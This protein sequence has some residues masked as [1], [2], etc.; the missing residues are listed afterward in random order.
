MWGNIRV[1]GLR[2]GGRSSRFPNAPGERFRSKVLGSGGQGVDMHSL[3]S[4]R[5][6]TQAFCRMSLNYFRSCGSCQVFS[7]WDV[8]FRVQILRFWDVSMT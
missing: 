5:T 8:G 1:Y 7:K 3:R 6:P 4:I 2:F